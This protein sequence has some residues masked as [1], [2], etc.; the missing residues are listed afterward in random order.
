VG[1]NSRMQ[2]QKQAAHDEPFDENVAH[3]VAGSVSA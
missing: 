3:V 2:P 1:K